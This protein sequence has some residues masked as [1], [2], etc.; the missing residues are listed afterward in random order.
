MFSLVLLCAFLARADE[1]RS[2]SGPTDD[3]ME[4]AVMHFIRNN[5]DTGAVSELSAL[6]HASGDSIGAAAFRSEI[7]PHQS[8]QRARRSRTRCRLE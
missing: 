2:A 5:S 6:L 7:R 3:L 4:S 1:S 8:L